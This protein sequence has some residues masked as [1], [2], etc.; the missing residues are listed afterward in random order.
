VSTIARKPITI[1]GT[2]WRD[3]IEAM[4]ELGF[5]EWG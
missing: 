2:R 3:S 4:S 5:K 1:L